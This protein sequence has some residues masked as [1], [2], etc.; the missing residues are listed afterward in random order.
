MK[1]RL[2]Y[3]IQD[4]SV[5]MTK[6]F[7]PTENFYWNQEQINDTGTDTGHREVFLDGPISSR[8]AILDFNEKT[9]ELEAPV[10]L[11][12]D[13]DTQFYDIDATDISARSTQAVSTFS[14][15][16]KTLQAFESPDILGRPIKWTSPG[17]QLLVVPFAGDWANAFYERESASL[18]FFSFK[19]DA[20]ET[21][22]SSQSFDIVAHET[23]HAILDSVVPG[24]Y[25]TITPESLALHEAIA[26]VTAL[27]MAISSTQ[28]LKT[29]LSQTNNTI[30]G[31]N[32][33]TSIAEEFGKAR[34]GASGDPYLRT[35]DNK[36]TMD[37]VD[38]TNAHDLSQVLSGTLFGFLSDI[39]EERKGKSNDGDIN[40]ET[41]GKSLFFANQIFRRLAFRALDYLPPGEISFADYGRAIWAADRSSN[42]DSPEYREALAA[43]FVNRK[44]IDAASEL[45][46]DLPDSTVVDELDIEALTD[47]DWLA[48]DFVN[49]NRDLL[50]IP[51]EV[52]N[53]QVLPRLPVTKITYRTGQGQV[54]YSE[55]LFKVRWE[56]TEDNPVDGL[57]A[58]RGI[59]FGTTLAIKKDE[60]ANK[61]KTQ[62]S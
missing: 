48:Y 58:R 24:L 41:I 2:P 10:K 8:V 50:H 44:I 45:N 54:H 53:F 60:D 25:D 43:A 29:L 19:D 16:M 33:F 46:T 57:P 32:A 49:K 23:G 21:I 28:L 36:F 1:V 38:S 42:P 27:I 15:V 4:R 37:D 26:D 62:P 3:L 61:N 51:N 52:T 35:L 12:T 55:L 47:S 31:K 20:G 14:T 18:Q 17:T 9:G 6:G 34:G 30:S 5:A 11:L 56:T 22:H 39:F 7:E 59:V 40:P 13:G